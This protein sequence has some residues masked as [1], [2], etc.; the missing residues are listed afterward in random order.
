MLFHGFRF[1]INTEFC[2]NAADR[3]QQFPLAAIIQHTAQLAT[4]NYLKAAIMLLWWWYECCKPENNKMGILPNATET[5]RI[6][7]IKFYSYCTVITWDDNSYRA[8]DGEG[9]KLLE[10]LWEVPEGETAAVFTIELMIE[11]HC[12][13]QI[14]NM[15]FHAASSNTANATAAC[16]A[17]LDK[18]QHS[19]HHIPH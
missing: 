11:W 3:W 2:R 9:T 12:D 18:H 15:A 13:D 1:S 8:A 10:S 16:I 19:S 7:R 5:L 6:A 4:V 17:A 14:I